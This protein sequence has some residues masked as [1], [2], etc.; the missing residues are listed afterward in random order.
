[1]PLSTDVKL[2][3]THRPVFPARCVWSG[4]DNPD[5][6][7]QFKVDSLSWSSTHAAGKEGAMSVIDVPVKRACKRRLQRQRKL[8]FVLYGVYG[9]VGA[10]V[11]MNAGDWLGRD[12]SRLQ[13]IL[14]VAVGLSPVIAFQI[15]MP[16]AFAV[17][18]SGINIVYEFK[19]AE[20]ASE[21]QA[22]NKVVHDG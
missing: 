9:I 12:L 21:F 14:A 10:V 1:M 16:P 18:A 4:E 7:E 17:R 11:A 6:T 15:F 2:P 19:S 8:G 13:T 3:R 5:E 22:L 20:Y